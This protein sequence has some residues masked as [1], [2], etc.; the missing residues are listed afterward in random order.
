MTIH[1]RPLLAS[2]LSSTSLLVF[3]YLEWDVHILLHDWRRP[4]PFPDE[5]P[6]FNV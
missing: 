6:E 5:Q 2:R 4:L 1:R 3:L